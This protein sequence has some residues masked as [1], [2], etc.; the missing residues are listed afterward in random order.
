MLTRQYSLRT[1][2]TYLKWI[3][4]FIHFHQKRHPTSMG[5][6]EVESIGSETE[7]SPRI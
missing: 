7:G 5:D 1:I 6:N 2:E 3:T 4:S